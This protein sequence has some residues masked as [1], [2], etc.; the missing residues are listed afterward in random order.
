MNRRRRTALELVHLVLS[1]FPD[2]DEWT[3]LAR[4]WLVDHV[5]EGGYDAAHALS[6]E[7]DKGVLVVG[8]GAPVLAGH[9]GYMARYHAGTLALASYIPPEDVCSA[10]RYEWRTCMEDITKLCNAELDNRVPPR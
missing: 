1:A 7:G 5:G 3:D 10:L 6:E 9:P 8:G 2:D 4:V